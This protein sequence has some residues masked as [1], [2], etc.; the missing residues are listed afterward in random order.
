MQLGQR[1]LLTITVFVWIC[2]SRVKC[3]TIGE[4][5]VLFSESLLL[6]KAFEVQIMAFGEILRLHLLTLI[7]VISK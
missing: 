1:I 2:F 7:N 6:Q 4:A 3:L 5:A